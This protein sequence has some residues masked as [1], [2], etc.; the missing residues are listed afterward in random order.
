MRNRCVLV[1]LA[2]MLAGGGQLAEARRLSVTE[3]RFRVVLVPF[4]ASGEGA[5]GPVQAECN[6]TLVGS[7]HAATGA[8][9]AGALIGHIHTASADRTTCD[10]TGGRL[11]ILNGTE[12]LAGSRT[13]NLLP[14]HIVYAS[15]SGTLPSI[16]HVK[17][18]LVGAA[19]LLQQ[20]ISEL[21][22]VIEVRCLY[23]STT[24]NPMV[25]RFSINEG[26]MGR[27]QIMEEARVPLFSGGPNCPNPVTVGGT[28]PVTGL[29]VSSVIPGR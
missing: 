5:L 21:F 11:W 4:T 27:V 28:G 10:P 2:L 24:T 13:L 29:G 3:T 6:V 26:L 8:K 15:Y 19:F 17:V 18:N 20:T 22:L 9:T 7:L 23:R 1:C 12:E 14:W 16:T 25:P